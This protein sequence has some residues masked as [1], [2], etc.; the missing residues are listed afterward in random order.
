MIFKNRF[1]ISLFYAILIHV[2][3]VVILALS[4]IFTVPKFQD[5]I[6]EI[7]LLEPMGGH[8]GGAVE[9]IETVPTK[10]NLKVEPDPIVEKKK[11]IIKPKVA[12][13]TIKKVVKD[14]HKIKKVANS[15]LSNNNNNNKGKGIEDGNGQGVGSGIGKGTGTGKGQ[16]MEIAVKP[17][18][19]IKHKKPSY[20]SLA[21]KN[22]IEGITRIKILINNLGKV[23][24]VIV[25]KS[26]G[27][28]LLDEAA[29]KAVKKWEFIPAKNKDG[30]KIR[31]YASMPI[32]FK[33]KK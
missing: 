28:N 16:A 15:K 25:A 3:I 19:I 22:G 13:K 20:P 1:K 26:S 7:S 14:P 12:K 18:K 17:P 10:V 11:K 32:V 29:V 30:H 21:K 4:G 31:C 33:I 24:D 2:L 23:E 27:S 8:A 9:E 6:V 5:K